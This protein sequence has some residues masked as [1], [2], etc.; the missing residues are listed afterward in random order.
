VFPVGLSFSSARC[1]PS[2]WP[3]LL[4][5]KCSAFAFGPFEAARAAQTR[6]RQF[7]LSDSVSAPVLGLLR[8][9]ALP[10][11]PGFLTGFFFVSVPR[12]ARLDLRSVEDFA[13]NPPPRARFLMSRAAESVAASLLGLL[14]KRAERVH[15]LSA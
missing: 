10:P 8:V 2:P 12:V 1:R 3:N 5:A 7:L 4:L 9:S 15:Q 6:S 11:R 13:A 14:V